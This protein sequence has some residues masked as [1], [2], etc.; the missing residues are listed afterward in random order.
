MIET[1][2]DKFTISALKGVGLNLAALPREALH[3]LQ[4]GVIVELRAHEQQNLQVISEQKINN[5][6]MGMQQ[7]F[8]GTNQCM[9][10][11]VE[12]AKKQ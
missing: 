3:L 1:E 2:P 8:T 9:I 12:E 11:V 4:D 7:D 10:K 6:Q 5:N